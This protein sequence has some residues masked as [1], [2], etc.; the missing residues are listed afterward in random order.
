MQSYITLVQL[1]LRT[2]KTASLTL[3][4]SSISLSVS[5]DITS[6]PTM[7]EH[8]LRVMTFRTKGWPSP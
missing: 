7:G 2:P 1:N 3:Q 4:A 8:D 5:N 6:T